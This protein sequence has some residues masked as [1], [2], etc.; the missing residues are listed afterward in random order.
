[1][2]KDL[3]MR[4][5]F[6]SVSPEFP[7]FPELPDEARAVVL[8]SK[9]LDRIVKEEYDVAFVANGGVAQLGQ[10]AK[11]PAHVFGVFTPYLFADP[12]EGSPYFG[13]QGL[14]D[15]TRESLRDFDFEAVFVRESAI[16]SAR[17]AEMAARAFFGSAVPVFGLSRATLSKWILFTQSYSLAGQIFHYY[18]FRVKR[19]YLVSARSFKISTGAVGLVLAL[20]G[21]ASSHIKSIDVLGIGISEDSYPQ[22]PGE[23]ASR[24]PHVYADLRLLQ[25]V[26]KNWLTVPIF[27]DDVDLDRATRFRGGVIT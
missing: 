19:T 13:R 10:F 4:L 15:S 8:G 24:V 14:Y 9:P 3:S 17:R 2:V 23:V 18:R 7:E 21:A 22:F 1:M 26:R 25:K 5:R 20:L 6:G 11:A 16:Y 12:D 27:V